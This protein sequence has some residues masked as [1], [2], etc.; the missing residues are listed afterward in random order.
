MILD[1]NNIF[2]VIFKIENFKKLNIK[3][4]KIIF[5]Y[6]LLIVLIN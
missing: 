3:F 6:I 2:I 5:N 1:I 4:M